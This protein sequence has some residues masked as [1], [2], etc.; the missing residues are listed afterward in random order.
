MNL[1]DDLRSCCC[2]QPPS[3]SCSSSLVVVSCDWVVVRVDDANHTVIISLFDES[4]FYYYLQLKFN[5]FDPDHSQLVS[6][7]VKK[8]ANVLRSS[9]QEAFHL[10]LLDTCFDLFDL[11]LQQSN[12]AK[13]LLKHIPS[14]HLLFDFD[15]GSYT[16]LRIQACFLLLLLHVP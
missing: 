3:E 13:F 5:S 8:N 6:E 4:C 1:S 2:A 14:K 16:V 9:Q 7:Q 11:C 10:T 12:V 15:R